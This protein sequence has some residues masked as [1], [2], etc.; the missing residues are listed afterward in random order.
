MNLK[1]SA[2]SGGTLLRGPGRSGG[3]RARVDRSRRH[4]RSAPFIA[5]DRVAGGSAGTAAPAPS[6]VDLRT[7]LQR[8]S[9]QAESRKSRPLRVAMIGQKGVPATFGGIEHHVE[10]I[11]ARL[12]ARGVKVTVYC[13]RSY[14]EKTPREYRGMRLVCTPTL[15]TKHLDALVHSVTSTLHA[16]ASGADVVHYH[17]LGP[18]LAAPL[19]RFASR[20][21]VILTVH[22]LDH[23]RAKWSGLAQRVLGL[24]YWMSGRVPDVVVTVSKTLAERY[25]VDF[26][27]PATYIPNGVCTPET[28]E[29]LGRLASEFGL[30]AGGYVLFVGRIVPEKRT[31]LLIEAARHLPDGVKVV[32][33]GDSSFS[34]EY[35]SGIRA[36]ASADDRLVLPGYLYGSELAAVYQGAAVFVQPSDVEG[37]PLTLLEALSYRIPVVASDID[38]HQE[39]LGQCRCGGHRLFAAGDAQALADELK[40]ALAL[41]NGSREA[42]ASDG[43]RLL[44]P[45]D[46]DCSTDELLSLYCDVTGH[47]APAA[48]QGASAQGGHPAM[49]VRDAAAR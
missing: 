8:R 38:P 31:D 4:R 12:A 19:S 40:A 34:D 23:E 22:G 27:R 46:W 10:E 15:G 18:G 14:A 28:G 3:I 17:G 13:R 41:G 42:V 25:R 48:R 39:V 11:G 7:R 43:E 9:Q 2:M 26:A 24:A 35:V 45:Y 47:E 49:L 21:K 16:M 5:L 29:P 32:V 6:R 20:A 33:V 37:L 44:A 1:M 36:A 30:T